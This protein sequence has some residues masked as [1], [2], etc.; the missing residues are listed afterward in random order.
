MA[1]KYTIA[2]HKKG[3]KFKR[4]NIRWIYNIEAR[5]AEIAKSKARRKIGK[6]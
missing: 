1:K 3:K 2:Y 6:K 5:T 4:A